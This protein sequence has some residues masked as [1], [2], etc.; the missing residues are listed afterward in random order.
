MIAR[1]HVERRS[2]GRKNRHK[3]DRSREDIRP[4]PE[5]LRLRVLSGNRTLVSL[6][7]SPNV[8]PGAGR[9]VDRLRQLG[10]SCQDFLQTL[11]FSAA[12]LARGDVIRD[13]AAR[14]FC[15]LAHDIVIEQMSDDFVCHRSN[16]S[17]NS[18]R[19]RCSCALTVPTETPSCSAISWCW[20]PSTSCSTNAT[21]APFGSVA[22]AF[23]MSIFNSTP[24]DRA[25][26]AS[27]DVSSIGST[28]ALRLLSVL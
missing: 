27:R 21:R 20:Y 22:I 17:L 4:P 14:I 8:E 28:L 10:G 13:R 19:A 1:I 7:G 5:S 16:L 18:L 25:A 9:R 12:H 26:P 2:T 24:L 23:S 15:Q 6:D 11:D 3:D